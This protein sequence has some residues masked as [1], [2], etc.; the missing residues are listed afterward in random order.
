MKLFSFIFY[1]FFSQTKLWSQLP[2][3]IKYNVHT[4]IV[5]TWISQ[6]F[7][8]KKLFLFFK[9]NFMRI[10]HCKFIHHKSHLKPFLSYLPWILHREYFSI[11]FNVKRAHYTQSST[12][13]LIKYINSFFVS[14][15]DLDYSNNSFQ[16][17]S[18]FS[19]SDQA[20]AFR[21]V[22]RDLRHREL[23]QR[24]RTAGTNVIKFYECRFNCIKNC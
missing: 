9:N 4:S 3:F 6:W 17:S 16:S 23:R 14:R 24:R 15:V 2:H 8:A 18:A 1:Q 7:L 5:H 10:N 20:G 11:I 22:H 19:I 21:W 13:I 12:S